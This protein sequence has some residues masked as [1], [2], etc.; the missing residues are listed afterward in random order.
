M[1]GTLTVD[2]SGRVVLPVAVRRALGLKAGSRMVV[3]V[4][5]QAVTLTPVREA[6]RKAQGILA[7]YRP[8]DGSLLSEAMV[9]ERRDEYRREQDH[10]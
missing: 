6:I 3:A 10:P 7:P 2:G 4:E 5:G 9:A 8:A 1:L